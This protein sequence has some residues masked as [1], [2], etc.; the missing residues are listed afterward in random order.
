MHKRRILQADLESDWKFLRQLSVAHELLKTGKVIP[1]FDID[2]ALC[3]WWML[4]GELGQI[5][6]QDQL[7]EYVDILRKRDGKPKVTT[8]RW[9]EVLKK[10]T[11]LLSRE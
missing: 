4:Y 8:R 2:Y 5:P 6:G 10:L 11:P 3:A 1:S 9:R 7:R